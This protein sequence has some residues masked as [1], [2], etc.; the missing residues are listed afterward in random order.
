L[1]TILD[2]GGPPPSRPEAELLLG[3]ARVTMDPE[4][5]GRMRQ[6]L[7]APLDWAFLSRMA[8]RHK[9]TPLLYQHLNSLDVA[10]DHL[11][12]LRQ[13]FERNIHR[14]L[15]LSSELIHV[16]KLFD[17]QRIPIL[18]FK[19]PTLASVA[20]GN[21]ALRQ[22]AD[23][24][25]LVPR[26]HVAP[27]QKLLLAQG[28]RPQLSFAAQEARLLR[29]DCQRSFVRDD[30]RVE[31]ELH[32]DVAPR[33]FSCDL[34]TERFWER[35]QP[36]A[37]GGASVPSLSRED[38]LLVLCVHGAKHVWGQLNWICDVSELLRVSPN[39]D[40]EAVRERAAAAGAE[41]MLW[42]GL[43][44]AHHVL[45][46][47][48]PDAIARRLQ[49]RSELRRLTDQ[50]TRG[51]FI[52]PGGRPDLFERSA[53]QPLAARVLFHPFHLRVRERFADRI[54]YCLRLAFT[55]S[56]AD[57]EFVELPSALFFLYHLLRP[58]RLAGKYLVRFFRRPTTQAAL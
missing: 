53:H 25:I 35:S 48:L 37:L 55:P 50:V 21:L 41:R 39:L 52:E 18:P 8:T 17:A 47:A 51:L 44:L 42:L 57:W 4:R 20:Y 13:R 56:V 26:E 7:E 45:G 2:P 9:V 22:F 43:F 40:W 58:V 34:D 30:G 38:L 6:L 11:G 1:A 28:Y 16:L 36:A 3:C 19:G 15:F 5:A 46:A 14:N 49:D 29:S 54:R 23:L 31:V 24:D 33:Y 12:E 10:G 32:W 27:A